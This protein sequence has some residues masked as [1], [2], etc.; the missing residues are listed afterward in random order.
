M[1]NLKLVITLICVLNLILNCAT[2]TPV[3][4]CPNGQLTPISVKVDSCT[5]SPCELWRGF[6]TNMEIQF[7]ALKN[8]VKNI[9]ADV[10]MSTLGIGL[11]L[12]LP[13]E[14]KD[15]CKNLMFGANCPMDKD[16]DATYHLSL[17][18]GEYQPEVPAK[19]EVSIK[20]ANDG[21]EMACFILDARI[22]K[23]NGPMK[24]SV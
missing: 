20:D 1:K 13:H 17:D 18:I 6:A 7:V 10:R 15:V 3:R 2:E 21:S 4:K 8:S 11:P 23:R 19:L 16:E 22:T 9:K 14:S 5:E 12:D 24:A